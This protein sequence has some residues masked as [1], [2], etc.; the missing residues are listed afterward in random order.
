MNNTERDDPFAG[1]ARGE[2]DAFARLAEPH[3]AELQRFALR[4]TGGDTSLGEEVM[5]EALLNAYRALRAGARPENMRAWLYTLVRNCALNAR[6]GWCPV[7]ALPDEG[8]G[9]CHD[10]A[11]RA[12]EQREWM[13]WLMGA[14]VALP[15]RQRDALLA[16]AFEGR[17]QQEIAG[18]MGTSVPAVKT[19]LHRARRTLQ[20]GQPSSLATLSGAAT[21]FARRVRGHAHRALAAKLGTKGAAAA[22][23][24][25]LVAATVAASVVLVAHGGADPVLASTLKPSAR[26]AATPAAPRGRHGRRDHSRAPRKTHAAKVRYEARHALRECTNGRRLSRGLSRAALRY[27]ARHMPEELREYSDCEQMLRHA[28]LRRL[29]GHPKSRHRPHARAERRTRSRR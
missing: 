9:G 2:S 19:L 10:A 29:I 17:S 24:Q 4:M 16:S 3:R 21:A 26:V 12:V 23:W 1:V 28:Q 7:A 27:A 15:V 20:A 11:T 14:I 5:Q 13:D 18:S 6:R 25:V 22:G 8:R